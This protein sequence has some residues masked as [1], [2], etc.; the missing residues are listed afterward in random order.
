MPRNPVFWMSTR[1]VHHAP[2]VTAL[3]LV[4]IAAA[5]IIAGD[6][7]AQRP[8]RDRPDG[9]DRG[10]DRDNN[11]GGGRRGRDHEPGVFDYY[12]LAL[13]WSPTFCA[14]VGDARDDPQCR[15]R[16]DRPYA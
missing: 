7:L 14:D 10:Y 9:Y 3:A 16:R 8:Y 15:P 12:V 11:R 4:S 5:S 1:L 6:A 13:S 2:V